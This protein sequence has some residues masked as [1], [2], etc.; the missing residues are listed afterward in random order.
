[1]EAEGQRV[2]RWRAIGLVAQRYVLPLPEPP[3]LPLASLPSSRRRAVAHDRYVLS[4][5]SRGPLSLSASEHALHEPLYADARP[6]TAR[7]NTLAFRTPH[8]HSHSQLSLSPG[9][10][11]RSGAERRQASYSPSLPPSLSAIEY[12]P[13]A[14]MSANARPV[15][16]RANN[17]RA[18]QIPSIPQ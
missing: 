15:T 18:Y 13:W 8:S 17:K 7:A 1:M 5:V 11:S 3:P 12:N 10:L 4:R 9:A 14:G 2:T 16:V 6:A